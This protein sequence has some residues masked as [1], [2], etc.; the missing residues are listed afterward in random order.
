MPNKKT[1]TFNQ[2]IHAHVHTKKKK[3]SGESSFFF[4]EEIYVKFGVEKIK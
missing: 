4:L 1:T 2:P 3:K